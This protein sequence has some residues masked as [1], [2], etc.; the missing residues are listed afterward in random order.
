MTDRLTPFR[1]LAPPRNLTDEVVGRL[2]AEITGGGLQPGARL[3]TEQAMMSA[4]GVSRTV[5]RE[6]VAAL[7]AEGLVVTR[8]GVGAFVATDAK[9]RPF[10][11]DPDGIES[12]GEAIKV[13]EL[14]RAVEIE[15]AGLAAERGTQ[16]Q[17]EHIGKALTAMDRAISRGETAIDEDRAFHR[18]VAEATGNPQFARF[19]EFLGHF[20]IPRRA[21]ADA[22]WRKDGAARPFLDLFQK[23][24]RAIFEAIGD[25][26]AEGA[27]AAM[28]RHLTNSLKRYRKLA[29][30]AKP[31]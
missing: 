3:P 2:A 18:A 26:S 27:R 30:G 29:E 14:R 11:L 5:V 25:R 20:V 9:R 31:A 8:Q 12:L 15:A 28:R 13:M 1:P 23:E 21:V 10:R 19:L 24:H 7:R 17:I 22:P 6:A 4:M 16:S